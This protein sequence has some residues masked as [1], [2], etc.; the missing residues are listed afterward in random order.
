MTDISTERAR[1]LAGLADAVRAFSA[2]EMQGAAFA[3]AWREALVLGAFSARAHE[4]SEGLL[5]RVE[6]AQNFGGES[7]SFSATEIADAFAQLL[8]KL[9]T[10]K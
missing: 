4:V 10:A 5:M 7:C 3:A 6:S 2:S 1:A 9:K 8:E